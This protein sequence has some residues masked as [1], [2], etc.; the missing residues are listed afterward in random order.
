ME[1]DS[2]CHIS[3]LMFSIIF[4][5]IYTHTHTHREIQIDV[6]YYFSKNF[7]CT[8]LGLIW[9]TLFIGVRRLVIVEAGSKHVEGIVSLG[10]VFRFLMGS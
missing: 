7:L 10:D 9:S 5:N 4:H 3:R 1:G 8:W 2:A 6:E